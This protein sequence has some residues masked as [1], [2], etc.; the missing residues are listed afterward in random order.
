MGI[1]LTKYVFMKIQTYISDFFSFL[2][3]RSAASAREPKKRLKN[4]YKAKC[5]EPSDIC[6]HLPRLQKLAM[7][8]ATVTEIGVRGMVSTWAILHGL[9]ENP[10]NA[11]SYIGIDIVFPPKKA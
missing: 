3:A 4:I 7:E 6:E 9:M 10:S 5:R 2:L 11:R 8:S 1:D